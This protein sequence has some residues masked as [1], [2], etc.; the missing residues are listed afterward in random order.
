MYTLAHFLLILLITL[1]LIG[2]HYLLQLG[3]VLLHRLLHLST[4]LLHLAI[5]GADPEHQ[6]VAWVDD[7]RPDDRDDDR[8]EVRVGPS[9]RQT[10]C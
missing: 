3:F 4:T 1:V 9:C 10:W 6:M 8:D 2:G 5:R 7:Q